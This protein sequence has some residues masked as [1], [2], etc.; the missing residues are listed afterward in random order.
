[1]V[2]NNDDMRM[3]DITPEDLGCMGEQ[4]V[5]PG[6]KE[7]TQPIKPQPTT[8][9]AIFKSIPHETVKSFKKLYDGFTVKDMPFDEFC[10]EMMMM[11]NPGVMQSTLSKIMDRKQQ[12][13]MHKAA[14]DSAIKTN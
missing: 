5:D 14:I 8:K 12:G 7:E 11:S 1:M 2:S 3:E 9:E 4:E 6:V 10:V 13:Y